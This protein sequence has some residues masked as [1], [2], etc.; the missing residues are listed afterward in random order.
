MTAGIIWGLQALAGTAICWAAYRD[1]RR[2]ESAA[3]AAA[4]NAA[5]EKEEGRGVL[6]AI[7]G[8]AYRKAKGRG[9]LRGGF[10]PSL[11]ITALSECIRRVDAGEPVEAGVIVE[12]L[13]LLGLHLERDGA[14][15]VVVCEN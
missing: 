2:K 8:D 13:E 10:R 5:A 12:A 15:A 9:A 4:E 3:A 7:L 14:G 6:R 11:G 1:R